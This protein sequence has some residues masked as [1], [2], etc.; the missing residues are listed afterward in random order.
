MDFFGIGTLELILILIVLLIVVGPARLPEVAGAI[1]KGIRKF[2]AATTELSRDFKEM[3]EEVKDTE[4][5][6]NSM[7]SPKIGL[8]GELNKVAGEID[9]VRKEMNTALKS[10]EAFLYQSYS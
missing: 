9:N 7:M 5:E 2:R 4:N 6:V 10:D 8:T 3:A 1:G